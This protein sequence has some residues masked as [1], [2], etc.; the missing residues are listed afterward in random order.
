MEESQLPQPVTSSPATGVPI[1]Q[2][3][4]GSG[5]LPPEYNMAACS[6]RLHDASA[7]LNLKPPPLPRRMCAACL[8]VLHAP[9]MHDPL[10]ILHVLL[11]AVYFNACMPLG[12]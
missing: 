8:H 9:S 1:S 12:G 6:P 3:V 4:D 10:Y 7:C 2:I 5:L 11:L